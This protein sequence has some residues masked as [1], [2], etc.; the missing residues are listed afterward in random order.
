MG[1]TAG[2]FLASI[3]LKEMRYL[4]YIRYLCSSLP[5][6][7]NEF[8]ILMNDNPF[9]VI[10]LNETWLNLT[11]TDA[12]LALNDYNL[13]RNDRTDLQEPLSAI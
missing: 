13:I 9:D 3:L 8:K 1:V 6:H 11:W 2:I 4:V 7:L 5:K 10:C 12:E